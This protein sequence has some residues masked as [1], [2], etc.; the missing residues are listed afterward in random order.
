MFKLAVLSLIL[1]AF[2][3]P[4]VSGRQKGEWVKLAPVGAG[5][6][7]MMPA[8]PDDE[9]R[10]GEE[11]SWHIFSLTTDK[12]IYIVGYGDYPPDTRF[13]V[14]RELV[15]NRD[16][17]LK[18]LGA[19]LDT[20]KQIEAGGHRGLEFTGHDDK[21]EIKSRLYIFGNR[22]HQIATAVMGGEND[23]AN[24][25]RFFASFSFTNS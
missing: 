18:G 5:F 4:S 14:D 23:S 22:I 15:T 2:L 20:S 13:N 16:K 9:T 10:M 7:V 1:P 19:T 8:K 25:D 3:L 11:V 12:T 6:S 21:T 24:V 17:F